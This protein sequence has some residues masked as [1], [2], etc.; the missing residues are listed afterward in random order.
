MFYFFKII[1]ERG[2]GPTAESRTPNF[3]FTIVGWKYRKKYNINCSHKSYYELLVAIF[4]PRGL[5]QLVDFPT[6]SRTINGTE[7][8]SILDHIYVE[9]PTI[10]SNLEAT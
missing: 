9:D 3:D 2:V 7:R 1:R 4:V 10:V 8:T 5:I 6:W